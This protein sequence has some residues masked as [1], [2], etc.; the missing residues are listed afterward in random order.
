MSE[1]FVS[2]R[3]VVCVDDEGEKFWR[4]SG[5]GWKDGEDTTENPQ[6]DIATLPIGAVL[7]LMEPSDAD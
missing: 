3:A 6:F 5:D 2:I 4:L 1:R 7:T